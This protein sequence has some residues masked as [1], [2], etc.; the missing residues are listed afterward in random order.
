[1]ALDKSSNF[2]KTTI[3]GIA[4][5]VTEVVLDDATNFLDPASG[6]YNCVIWEISNYGN[7][8][9][10]PNK[11]IV[12][13]TALSGNTL[14][15]T[16]AQESTIASNHNTG[17][18]TY[19][20]ANVLTKKMIDDIDTELDSKQAVLGYVPENV[21]NKKT[22][23][24]DNSDTYY[25]T[26]KAVKTVVDAKADIASPTFTGTVTLPKTVEIQDTTGDHQYVLGVSELTADRTVTL[27]LLTGN[28]TFMFKDFHKA[29]ASDINTGTEDNKY[30]TPKGLA[31]SNYIKEVVEDTTPQLGGNLDTNTK[32]IVL[33]EGSSIDLDKAGS[34][35]EKW[36]GIAVDGTAGATLAVGDLCY[37]DATAGEWLL[38]DAD[39]I[40]TAGSVPLGLCILA[41]GDGQATKLLLIGTMRSAAFPASI[42][43][44]APLYVSTTAGDITATMPT[45]VDDVVR[46]VGFA[47][48][49]EPN[50]IYFNPET[51][52]ITRTAD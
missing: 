3:T 27:P 25:P 47:I 43:L 49:T 34:A 9:D 46:V 51:G 16:R 24:T 50:T 38:A 2:A 31:D 41:G 12:R 5:G 44:G 19:A 8:A 1:M 10:D 37:L 52:W 42:A 40:G 7:P 26:Q 18:E 17:G 36:T 6:E 23:L 11:E 14:T 15:I 30:V 29:S 35:D 20:I 48:T 4:S 33:S 39:A 22:S 32:N 21:A 13:A 28:D 45:G